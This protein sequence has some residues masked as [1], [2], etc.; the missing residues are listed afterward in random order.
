MLEL[1]R[2][3]DTRLIATNDVHYIR[4]EDSTLQDVLLCVQTGKLLSDPVRMRMAD[5]SFYL[6]SPEEMKLHFSQVP[7]AIE[8]TLEIAERCHLDLGRKGYH[9]PQFEV[10]AGETTSSYLRK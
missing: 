2:K 8:N 6:R 4:P 1:A 7:D 9:L 10:P 5:N 3:T